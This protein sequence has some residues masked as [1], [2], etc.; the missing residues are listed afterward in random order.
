MTVGGQE[1]SKGPKDQ[2]VSGEDRDGRRVAVELV[3]SGPCTKGVAL[4]WLAVFINGA[5]HLRIGDHAK[6]SGPTDKGESMA[7]LMAILEFLFG[8]HHVHL[9]RVFTLEG[10]TYRVC[11]NCGAKFAY[12]L[13]TMS[14]E[15]RL[16]PSPV[17]T[18]PVEVMP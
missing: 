2:R 16:P 14:I 12:S 6:E 7:I 11:C 10:K 4:V 15:R 8:C 3:N 18:R 1:Q 9:S 13:A 17:L 5:A